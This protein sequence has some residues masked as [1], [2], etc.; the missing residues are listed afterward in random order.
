MYAPIFGV[1]A[2]VYKLHHARGSAYVFSMAMNVNSM[3]DKAN[4]KV[5]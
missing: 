3:V 1:P 4:I 2:G 5:A